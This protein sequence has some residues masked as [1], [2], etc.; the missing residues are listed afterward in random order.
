MIPGSDVCVDELKIICDG[1]KTKDCP[2]EY[3]TDPNPQIKL[4][5]EKFHLLVL[6]G[7]KRRM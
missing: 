1:S 7:N 6:Y 4:C 2:C 3:M 5:P